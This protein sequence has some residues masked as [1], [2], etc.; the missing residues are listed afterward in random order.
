MQPE[1]NPVTQ[2]APVNQPAQDTAT[3]ILQNTT[4]V[5]ATVGML[6]GLIA[7]IKSIFKK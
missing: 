6:A 5:V 2:Q 7:T 4:K 1:N 3:K